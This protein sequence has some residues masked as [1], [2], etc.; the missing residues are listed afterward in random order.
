MS[1]QVYLL[2]DYN[3]HKKGDIIQV[4]NNVAFGLLDSGV[5][6]LATPADSVKKTEFGETKSFKNPPSKHSFGS[7]K[8]G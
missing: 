7:K 5:G 4:S 2:K 1:K 3:E 6:R 8:R